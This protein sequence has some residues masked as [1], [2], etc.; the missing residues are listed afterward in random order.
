[1]INGKVIMIDLEKLLAIAEQAARRAGTLLAKHMVSGRELRSSHGHDIKIAADVQSETCLINYLKTKTDYPILTEETGMIGR[2]VQD[3]CMW[4]VDPLD[5]SMN[6]L[7]GIPLN[8]IALGLWRKNKPVLGVIY[9]FHRNE[10]FAGI[11][12]KAA[13]LNGEQIKVSRTAKKKDAIIC[14]GFPVNTDYSAA[15]IAAL[16]KQIQEYKKVRLFGSAALS[17]AY[18][19]SGR[20]DAYYENDIMIWDVAAGLAIV[21]GAG[22]VTRLRPSV[23]KNAFKVYAA[24]GHF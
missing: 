23:K 11:A 18:V 5:G 20:V 14:T 22:G 19:A 6:F 24:N 4:V 1:M 12:D 16:I 2:E 7:R 21:S 10:L 3:G 8:C 15:G 9:D 13:W 17:L